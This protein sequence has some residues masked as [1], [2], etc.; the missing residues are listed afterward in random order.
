MKRNMNLLVSMK[1][2]VRS[3]WRNK[4][5]FFISVFS[6]TIGLAC[7]NLLATFF[8]HEYNIE[9]TN[10]NRENIYILRQDSPMEEGIKT[11]YVYQMGL[12]QIK[13]NNYAEIE[14][15]LCINNINIQSD[16]LHNGN[17]LPK[18]T[19]LETNDA[20]SNLFEYT[21]K[22]G[23]MNEVLAS[24]NKIALSEDYARKAFGNKP[25]IGE[26]IESF[27]S[28]GEHHSYQVGAIL[29]ERPQSLI[30]FDM[31]TCNKDIIGGTIFLKL[32]EGA[33]AQALQQKIKD[34]QVM[35]LIPGGKYYVDPI[36]DIYFS[37]DTS[38]PIPGFCHQTNVQLLYI[39]LLTALLVLAIACFNYSN[40]NLSRTVQQLKMIH[41]EKLMGAKLKEIRAQLFL[42][43][44][45][46]VIISF[47][48]AL[49]LINDI[50]PLFNDLLSVRLAYSFF[51][52]WQVLPLLVVFILLLS[53]IPGVYISHR[54]SRQSLSE[55]R[56]QYTGRSKQRLVWTL[57][58][59]QFILSLGL[60]Y[61]TTIA[62][63]QLGQ[64][65][66]LAS[67]FE[68]LIEVGDLFNNPSLYPLHQKLQGMDGIESITLSTNPIYGYLMDQ[69]IKQ[70]DGSEKHISKLF[71][72]T[73]STFFTTMN[74]RI[75]EGIHPAEALKK[76]G[77][78]FYINENYARWANVQ[79]EDI[80][81]KM[82]KDLDPYNYNQ[83]SV[84]IL[85]GIIENI[86]T[87]SLTNEVTAQ[88]ITL[89][90]NASTYMSQAG[91]SLQ[92]KL[93]PQ[94]RHETIAKIES[95]WKEMYPGYA[96]TYTDIHKTFLENNKETLQL[97]KVLNI[98]AL[99]ALVLIC[100]GV[101]GISWYAVRQRTRE[102]AI[103]KIHGASTFSIVWLLNRPF[104]ILIGIAYVITLPLVW[105]L[106]QHWLE[107]FVYRTGY[108]LGQFL[109][110]L[111]VVGMVS[112][113]TV[114]IHT[115]LAA[116]SDPTQSMKTE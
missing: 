109:L 74:I 63:G 59:M 70:P 98:Y 66:G 68:S 35:T 9:S 97:S 60:V 12:K 51:F 33:D 42:D 15:I 11:P 39:A 47:L 53:I 67:R 7:T 36:K 10:P 21:T 32:T 1:L 13:N 92:I 99:I 112:C 25:C 44:A 72:E 65:K 104:F 79:P 102:I 86:P 103:R 100:S 24:P 52:S 27:N 3:W 76:Y 49:L 4:T 84:E 57:V 56:K 110:P 26:I 46:T 20:L 85:A 55:Y 94:K 89:Y 22:E 18:A 95:L 96:F 77:S 48:L 106:M 5:Y 30:Q 88:E 14:Q 40:L 23:N 108:T 78:S 50:L 80:G 83:K 73:D 45:L 115:L 16:L 111:L 114:S 34:D 91:K 82:R 69:S 37:T 87:K 75:K 17:K 81:V 113:I 71:T 107:Q 29:K 64:I 62:Q 28:K 6:L 90:D 2:I 116:K 31:L 54:L 41:I 8:I 93:N 101:F 43:A 19:L 61:A 58:T 105:W 38:S